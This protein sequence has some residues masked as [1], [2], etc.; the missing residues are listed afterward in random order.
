[1]NE[2]SRR[3]LAVENT[4]EKIEN[5]L[6]F[7]S[8]YSKIHAKIMDEKV[9]QEMK[10]AVYGGKPPLIPSTQ[11]IVEEVP[12]K[13]LESPKNLEKKD[14]THRKSTEIRKSKNNLDS[15]RTEKFNKY[16]SRK[17]IAAAT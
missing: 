6:S 17:A 14:S 9:E 11:V 1:M 2:N 3:K 12:T 7:R 4:R 16:S 5:H 8:Q 13:I 15:A 10:K